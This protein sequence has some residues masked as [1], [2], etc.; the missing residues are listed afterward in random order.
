MHRSGTPGSLPDQLLK[1]LSQIFLQENRW[2]GACFLLGLFLGHWSYAAAAL[3]AALAGTLLAR[4]ARYPQAET[5]AGLYG[6]SP[7]LVGV[8]LVFLYQGT[9]LIWSL[10][11]LGGAMAAAVQRFF[12][13]RG[14]P[15]YTFPFIL[16][17]WCLVFL[18]GQGSG[19]P[20][21]TIVPP[22][23]VAAPFTW[24]AA[25]VLGFGQ[26]VFQGSLLPALLL[27]AGVLINRPLAALYATAAAALGLVLGLASGQPPEAVQLGLYGFNPVLTAIVFA[28]RGRKDLTWATVGVLATIGLHILLVRTD[29]LAPVGGVFT[30]PFVAGTWLTLALRKRVGRAPSGQ[31]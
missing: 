20:P 16:V 3:A 25:V 14:V 23:A 26:V 10:V 17:A 24:V 9:P 31:A 30:F 13:V 1:G 22:A 19:V 12:I 11:C 4:A 8:A 15:A 6:F 18:L 28:G 5:D 7:A 21:S 2:T 27:L 29:L